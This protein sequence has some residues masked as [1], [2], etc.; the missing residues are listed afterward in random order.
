MYKKKANNYYLQTISHQNLRTSIKLCVGFN[1]LNQKC[2]CLVLY[3]TY[4]V[5]HQ[6]R[7]SAWST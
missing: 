2:P 6:K 5:L 7:A 4:G 1:L 3:S